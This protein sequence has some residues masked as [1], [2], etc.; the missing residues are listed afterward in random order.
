[1]NWIFSLRTR[2]IVLYVGLLVIGFGA[3]AYWAGQQISTASQ[4][5][6]ERRTQS[7]IALVADGLTDV[8]E[9]YLDD[10]KVSR[11][12][13][14]ILLQTYAKQTT[15]DIYLMDTKGDVWLSSNA[16]AIE[17]NYLDQPEIIA[18]L[19]RRTTSDT[20]RNSSGQL[21]VYTAAALTHDEDI[22]A[23]V[24]LALPA[25][26]VEESIQQRWTTL[27]GGVAVLGLLVVITSIFLSASLTS[28]LAQ[29]QQATQQISAG[30]FAVS[31]PEKRRDEIGQVARAFNQMTRQ[32]QMML[33]EQKSF[34]SNASHELRTPLTT[35]QLRTEAMLNKPL[36]PEK[37]EQYIH[38]IDGEI[39]RMS[40]LV[41]SLLI[42]SRL[43]SGSAETG[44]NIIDLVRVAQQLVRQM[45]P[46]AEENNIALTLSVPNT[47]LNAKIDLNHLNI[48]FR[49]I[50]D[51]AIKYMGVEG[52]SIHWDMRA[53]ND[54]IA[55]TI[56]D[57]GQGIAAEDLQRVNER[58]YR[59]DKSHSRE[60]GGVGLGLAL[61]QSIV[62]I[63]GG[64]FDL[65]SNGL[66]QGVTVIV[67][68]KLATLPES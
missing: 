42:L 37:K 64:K 14:N 9:E 15:G 34:A 30:D 49:N 58:F 41:D 17:E 66:G 16:N 32:V 47:A 39:K 24:Q 38:E 4:E 56:T 29:L 33:D 62:D 67:H 40:R 54:A 2:L 65:Q 44:T 6:F 57:T 45:Q 35:I 31:L 51:N 10:D 23:I 3:L 53:E 52:G 20:R 46:L 26:E 19:N 5:D 12:D 22:L 36:T 59:A 28:P 27:G 25:G 55:S 8:V 50:L 21:T 13:V 18:A 68:W 61:V 48:V 60:I 1:M 63:Y 11:N 7:E 43:D